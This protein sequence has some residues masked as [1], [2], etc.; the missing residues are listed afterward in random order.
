M[1]T[2]ATLTTTY[3]RKHRM[4]AEA[5]QRNNKR[6]KET[7]AS[8]AANSDQVFALQSSVGA[9]I[10][11]KDFSPVPAMK[12]KKTTASRRLKENS[13]SKAQGLA[14]PFLKPQKPL[15]RTH[16]N[17][18]HSQSTKNS[19]VE[20]FKQQHHRR[21]SMP[22]PPRFEASTWLPL[23][24]QGI[25]NA[26]RTALSPK[27]DFNRPP[28]QMDFNS[29]EVD[30]QSFAG[31]LSA[32]S[33]PPPGS[34][35]LQ[36]MRNGSLTVGSDSSDEDVLRGALMH[37]DSSPFFSSS[38]DST[39]PSLRSAINLPDSKALQ[40]KELDIQRIF[41][42]LDIEPRQK[43]LRTTSLGPEIFLS[44]SR[45]ESDEFDS[46]SSNSTETQ[47]PKGRARRGTIRASEHNP[48]MSY[49]SLQVAPIA[50]TARRT[51]SGTVVGPAHKGLTVE[52]MPSVSHHKAEG[53]ATNVPSSPESDDELLITK[54][55]NEED[56]LPP[57]GATVY[58]A[59]T[60]TKRA[61]NGTKGSVNGVKGSANGTKGSGR[62]S[63]RKK[64]GA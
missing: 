48:S 31:S 18:I 59:A 12:S 6:I 40:A 64:G 14:S 53:K 45:P 44:S 30:L 3:S 21:P 13:S 49:D 1:S 10:S 5:L 8:S 26:P 50:P 19:P 34:T 7:P 46:A 42:S 51:R 36:L 24:Q 35:S 11:P 61:G 41:S 54:A 29:M 39:A 57:P 4:D 63:G 25:D 28:S 15:Q 38:S 2:P 16:A 27:V 52:Q 58:N 43:L 9:H 32:T 56:W 37:E 20:G 62:G 33:T 17:T 23:K 60:A 22:T 55:W 47:V